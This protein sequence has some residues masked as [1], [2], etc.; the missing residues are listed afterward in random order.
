MSFKSD[1]EFWKTA[2]DPQDHLGCG[3]PH[4]AGEI[5]RARFPASCHANIILGDR[6]D[7]RSVD[8]DS[9]KC[10]GLLRAFA[11][12]RKNV[13]NTVEARKKNQMQAAATADSGCS[14]GPHGNEPPPWRRW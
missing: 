14:P 3:R 8:P 2:R 10:E 9:R 5:G 12:G 4:T 11:M 7:F 13:F 6:P 1:N